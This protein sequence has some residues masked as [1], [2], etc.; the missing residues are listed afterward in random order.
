MARAKTSVIAEI[1][2][3]CNKIKNEFPH[4]IEDIMRFENTYN[5]NYDLSKE[6]LKYIIH[7]LIWVKEIYNQEIKLKPIRDYYATPEGQAEKLMLE[8]TIKENK[9]NITQLTKTHES[10]IKD[11]TKKYENDIFNITLSNLYTYNIIFEVKNNRK[12]NETCNC[13]YNMFPG[14]HIT[15]CNGKIN[16]SRLVIQD[17][18][19][20]FIGFDLDESSTEIK[21][22][23]TLLEISKDKVFQ[24]KLILNANICRKK[25]KEYNNN[26]DKAMD[27]LKNPF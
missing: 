14:F 6:P 5:E 7:D 16:I 12:Q 26:I 20:V 2:E 4:K 10:F 19:N 11:I 15:V 1:K 18:K 24:E 8:S 13:P 21:I 9:N 27:K 17:Y 22:M 23:E 25:I 3:I